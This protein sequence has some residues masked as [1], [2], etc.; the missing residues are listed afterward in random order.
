MRR[1]PMLVVFPEYPNL[2]P[3]SFSKETEFMTPFQ[4]FLF[5]RASEHG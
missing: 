4:A 5:P 1:P 3:Q 2:A